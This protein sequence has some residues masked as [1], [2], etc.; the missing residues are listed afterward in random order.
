MSLQQRLTALA[1]AVGADIKQ[2]Q[3]AST[4]GSFFSLVTVTATSASQSSFTIP[5]G[6]TP[7]AIVVFLNGSS[8]AP[9]HYTATNGATVVLASD[10]G[11]I[12]GSELVVLKLTAFQVADAL[13]LGGTAAD[14]SKL[15]GETPSVYLND[16]L[17]PLRS[18]EVSI[19]AAVSLS[20]TAFGKM[21]VCSGTTADYTVTLPA[22]S[23]NAGK[24]VSLRMSS[25]LTKFVTLKGSGSELIDGSNTR[26]MW[27]KET[28]DLMCT[29]TG[30]A[31]IAGKTVPMSCGMY[32]TA[33]ITVPNGVITLV[34][35]NG[36]I[37]DTTGGM[38]DVGLGRM[39]VRRSAVYRLNSNV[40]YQGGTTM[41][42]IQAIVNKNGQLGG[43]GS[44]TEFMGV[45]TAY[46]ARYFDDVSLVEGDYLE[47]AANQSGGSVQLYTNH[48]T[49]TFLKLSEVPEW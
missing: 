2:L 10:T 8:L 30:W 29:G 45:P 32:P 24:L 46:R 40:Y 28:V 12:V 36:V 11:V 5:G 35:L 22:A 48:P 34:P 17:S 37:Y 39:R 9:A 20:N 47:L 44:F 41:S 14:A 23:G 16:F 15:G 21:H 43:A 27:A 1:Q 31:K 33:P 42:G 3:Q 13:P 6:Y 38:A 49:W 25:A 26:V 7:G 18:P 4:P 19:T